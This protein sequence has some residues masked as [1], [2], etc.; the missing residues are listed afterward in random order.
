MNRQGLAVVLVCV[1]LFAPGCALVRPFVKD[2]NGWDLSA[3]ADRDGFKV[4]KEL[5]MDNKDKI[6]G[7]EEAVNSV[8]TQMHI[9]AF[10][11]EATD[12]DS[13]DKPE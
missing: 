10:G 6:F 13:G 8:V 2:L 12:E 9:E 3:C 1:I 4:C 5:F 11:V 7:G